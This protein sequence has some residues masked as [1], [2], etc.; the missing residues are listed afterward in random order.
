MSAESTPLN[1]AL[2]RYLAERTPGE[3]GFLGE[4]RA[5]AVEAG[6][7]AIQ[8]SPEQASFMQV[9]LKLSGARE[10]VEHG[11]A[12]DAAAVHAE[13]VVAHLVRRDEQDLPSHRRAPSL[14]RVVK[15][16]FKIVRL[17]DSRR[18][19]YRTRTSCLPKFL[20]ASSPRNADGALSIPSLIVSR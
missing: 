3:D 14:P 8:I 10:V 17:A 13:R 2:I 9:L 4:L 1:E 12:R 11:R 19:P 20:P 15:S 7:P 6:I 18:G 5:A 16:S